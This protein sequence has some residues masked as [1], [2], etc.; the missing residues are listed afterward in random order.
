MFPFSW[1]SEPVGHCKADALLVAVSADIPQG[2]RAR[3]TIHCVGTIAI[4][5]TDTI[6]IVWT[7][8]IA[9]V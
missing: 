9:I 6:A 7:D 4:V 2:F 1:L 5:W 3:Y 8:T